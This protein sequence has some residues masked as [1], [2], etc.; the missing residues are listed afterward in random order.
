MPHRACFGMLTFFWVDED[1][2]PTHRGQPQLEYEWVNF[3]A[4]AAR[5]VAEGICDLKSIGI[6]SLHQALE[7]EPWKRSPPLENVRERD[8]ELVMYRRTVGRLNSLVPAAA[9]WIFHAGRMI[10][11]LQDEWKA[12]QGPGDDQGSGESLWKGKN[13]FCRERWG[14]WKSRFAWVH[15]L[16]ELEFE[17]KAIAKRAVEIMEKIEKNPETEFWQERIKQGFSH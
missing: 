8:R 12:S 4:F 9:Q 6:N 17:A 15:G 10:F 5:L 3:N 13:G 7:D 11:H 14:F 1:L 16:K 2:P